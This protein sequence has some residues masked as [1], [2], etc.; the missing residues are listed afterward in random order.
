MYSTDRSAKGPEQSRFY[1]RKMLP[2]HEK[3]EWGFSLTLITNMVEFCQNY[4]SINQKSIC[5]R[6]IVNWIFLVVKP[7]VSESTVQNLAEYEYLFWQ[8]QNTYT[9]D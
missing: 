1:W 5:Y 3:G 8:N 7:D 6:S 4:R 2:E 9:R